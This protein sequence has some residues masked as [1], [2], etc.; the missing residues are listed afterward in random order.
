MYIYPY[1]SIF[2]F[3]K[4][5]HVFEMVRIVGSSDRVKHAYL[6]NI[7]HRSPQLIIINASIDNSEI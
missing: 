3:T 5:N 1:L 2:L 4:M 6:R 7:N